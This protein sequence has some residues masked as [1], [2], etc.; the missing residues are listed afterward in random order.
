MPYMLDIMDEKY[1]MSERSVGPISKLRPSEYFDSNIWVAMEPEE[2][3]VPST[4][5]MLGAHKLMWAS[6]WPHSEGF[7]GVLK[8]VKRSVSALSESDQRKILGET[9]VALY[10]LD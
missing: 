4:V 7:S 10:K 3:T 9:A 8:E 6:D 2:K 1:E 5:Q